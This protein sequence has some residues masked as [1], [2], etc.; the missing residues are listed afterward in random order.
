MSL[1]S[2]FVT[3]TRLGYAPSVTREKSGSIV[4]NGS[5]KVVPYM[6]ASSNN[7]N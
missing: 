5:K 7:N 2:A 6:S 3:P 4:S 1:K